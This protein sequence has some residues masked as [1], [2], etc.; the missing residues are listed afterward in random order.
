[1]N[2]YLKNLSLPSHVNH[3]KIDIGL[4]YS[5]PQSQIWLSH[6]PN[7]FVIGFE[8]NP[9]CI[10]SINKEG[11]IVKKN[12]GHG[13]PLSEENKNR[14][15][16]IP[17][18]LGNVKE[19]NDPFVNFYQMTNDCGTSSIY[20]PIDK[21]LGPIKNIIKVPIYSLSEFFVHFP[22]G[23]NNIHSVDYIKIDAQGS[24]LNILKSAGN[25]LRERVIYI[26]AEQ[27]YNQYENCS[28]NNI[29]EMQLY[30]ESIGF[31][32]VNHPNTQDPTFLNR[33][34]KHMRNDIFIYQQG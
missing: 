2:N 5:A 24:D 28:Q 25:Y 29:Y 13:T 18:A 27:E 22:W 14:F 12:E 7:L 19:E 10:E 32:R 26:T 15:Y 6:E 30:M 9:E 11:P 31:D 33:I 20:M 23:I 21:S 1:M 8:P 16:L 3:L 4:S 34:Y 17:V